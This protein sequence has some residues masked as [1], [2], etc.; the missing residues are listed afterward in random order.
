MMEYF[1]FTQAAGLGY[2]NVFNNVYMW[3]LR[4]GDHYVYHLSQWDMDM[5]FNK[6]FGSDEDTINLY[7][8]QAWRMLDLDVSSAQQVLRDVWNE[9]RETILSD[10]AMYQRVDDLQNMINDS[11]AY[12]RESEKYRGGAQELDLSE[13]QSFAV[14]HLHTIE[15]EMDNMWPL[16]TAETTEE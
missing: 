16:K 11:G 13:I 2:D 3:A 5:G 9:K 1:L 6:M 15:R 14:E 10:D 4:Q 8:K 7:L 12:L